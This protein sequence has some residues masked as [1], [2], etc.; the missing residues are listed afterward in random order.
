[1]DLFKTTS[2]GALLLSAFLLCG[3]QPGK[4][5]AQSPVQTLPAIDTIAEKMLVYQRA[6]GG[7]PKA[8]NNKVVDY[9]LPLPESERDAVRKDSLA[10]DATFDNNATTREIRHLMT[11]YKNTRN[12]AYLQAVEKGLDY[13]LKAQYDN[14][15]WPQFYPDTRQYHAQITYNDEAMVRVLTV[16]KDVSDGKRNFNLL[17]PKWIP[18]AKTAVEKGVS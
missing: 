14:G 17:D 12:P 3:C 1:M 6:I 4:P 13:I 7:W 2:M 11:A 16:L 10:I 9:K 8:V 5:L 18:L 15:G